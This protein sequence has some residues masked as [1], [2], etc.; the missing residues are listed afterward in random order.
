MNP[1]AARGLLRR[2]P[3]LPTARLQPPVRQAR[4]AD[5]CVAPGAQ[6]FWVNE[7]AVRR[8]TDVYADR[9]FDILDTFSA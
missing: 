4:L 8:G 3:R 6:L 2:G 1:E 5:R 9:F 7:A